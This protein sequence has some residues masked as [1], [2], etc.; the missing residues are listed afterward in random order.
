MLTTRA[1]DAITGKKPTG[2]SPELT[3]LPQAQ[4][5]AYNALSSQGYVGAAVAV[6]PSTGEILAMAS[7]PSYD[8]NGIASGSEEA[9]VE[10]NNSENSPLLNHATQ[11]PL[12]PG[13]TFKVLTTA[14]A[15]EQGAG[16]I[17][18]L[19]EPPA[20]PCPALPPPW[21]TTVVP[22]V[23]A[24]PLRCARPSLAPVTPPSPN[25]L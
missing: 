5:A 10:L 15:L 21:K 22:P 16:P 3:I 2:A 12:P 13:S 25:W 4:L 17:L 23:A 6:R 14:M 24:A 8:P 11:R 1:I 19:L 18:R 20:S 9:W 7:T